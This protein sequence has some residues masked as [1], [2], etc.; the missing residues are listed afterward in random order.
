MYS[1]FGSWFLAAGF[2]L[3]LGYLWASLRSGPYAPANPWGGTT[4]E[5][6]TQSPPITFNFED[7]PVV[8]DGPYD[9]RPGRAQA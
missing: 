2:L 4:L 9:Y 3:T 5:W 8:T 7:Q 6:R 1:T